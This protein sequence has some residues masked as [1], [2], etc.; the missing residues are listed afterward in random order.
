MA[1]P[2]ST[3]QQLRRLAYSIARTFL[4]IERGL[5]NPQDMAVYRRPRFMWWAGLA[6]FIGSQALMPFALALAPMSLLAPLSS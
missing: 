1:A 2:Q 3:E 5:R 4:E 6:S